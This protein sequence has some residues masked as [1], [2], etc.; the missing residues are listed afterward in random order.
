MTVVNAMISFGL[1]LLYLPSYRIWDWNPP[2]RA[3]KTVIVVYFLSNLFLVVVPFFPTSSRTYEKLPYW[4]CY[5]FLFSLLFF[6]CLGQW[7]VIDSFLPYYLSRIQSVASSLHSLASHIGI[8][9]VL[10]FRKGKSIDFSESGLMRKMV[11]LDTYSVEYLVVLVDLWYHILLVL[12]HT[13][14]V[15][16]VIKRRSHCNVTS[17]ACVPEA[18]FIKTGKSLA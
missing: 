14:N 17:T 15:K 1:L 7:V 13:R 9:G 5:S 2:F 11:F 6:F 8:Y 12:E 10:G 18:W 4:V 16:L 3:P